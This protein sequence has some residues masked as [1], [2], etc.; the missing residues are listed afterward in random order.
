MKKVLR[1]SE[2]NLVK[3]I[4]RVLVEEKHIN[5]KK[6]NEQNDL[7]YD[8]ATIMG[9]LNRNN[10]DEQKI[11]DIVKKYTDKASFKQFV[12][13]YK[14]KSGK[15]FV[16]D[17]YRAITPNDKAEW[18]DLKTHLS[19]LGITL[20]YVPDGVK[21][22]RFIATFTGLDTP[23][24]AAAGNTREKQLLAM[25]TSLGKDGVIH[26]PGSVNNNMKWSDYVRVFQ[27]TQDELNKLKTLDTLT[28]NREKQLL[29]MYKSV[30]N[31]II[32]NPSS[33]ENGTKWTDF[34][35]TYQVTQDELNKVIKSGMT[36]VDNKP[37][38]NT[39]VVNEPK[40]NT[41]PKVVRNYTTMLAEI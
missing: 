23:A 22:G 28:S 20:N 13:Q 14:S 16:T 40:G 17:M 26:A 12:D 6:L 33:V 39:N 38:G 9:E 15:D 7:G 34:L 31:G 36:N 29:A 21:D 41:K 2:S 10:S 25:Y 1:V 8:I 37:K 32:V 24:P 30:K 35:T 4:Q 3:L 18:M 5:P 19:S 27:V 11:V